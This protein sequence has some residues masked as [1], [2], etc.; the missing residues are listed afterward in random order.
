[1][2]TLSSRGVADPGPNRHATIL[3]HFELNVPGS[4]PIRR[5]VTPPFVS[6]CV[7]FLNSLRRFVSPLFGNAPFCANSAI[8]DVTDFFDEGL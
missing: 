6:C 4:L 7:R 1:M 5:R 8:R 3:L 2:S